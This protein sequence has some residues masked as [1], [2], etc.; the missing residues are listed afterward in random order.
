MKLVGGTWEEPGAQAIAQW[1]AERI[2][3]VGLAESFGPYTALGVLSNDETRILGGCVFHNYVPAYRSVDISTAS[4]NARWLTR[5]VIVG[6]M[7]YPYRTLDCERLTAVTPKRSASVRR[8]LEHFGFKREGSHPMAFGDFGDAISYGLLR[9][10]W[11]ARRALLDGKKDP[12]R[13]DAA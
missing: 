6:L 13:A 9:K 7:D 5:A 10:D 11:E 2:P 4:D 1:V 12:S 3:H 8:F